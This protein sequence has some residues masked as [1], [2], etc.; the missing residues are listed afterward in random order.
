MDQRA[1]RLLPWPLVRPLAGD[2]GRTTA[3]RAIRRGEFPAPIKVSPGRVA[4]RES[5]VLA[6]QAERASKMGAA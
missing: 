3:W 1:Q 5:D 4:W 2:I 6:W